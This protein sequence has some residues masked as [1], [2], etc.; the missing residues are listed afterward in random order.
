VSMTTASR[1]G[2]VSTGA[3]DSAV[4]H[5]AHRGRPAQQRGRRDS[6]AHGRSSAPSPG[7]LHTSAGHD[8]ER[9][10]A[11]SEAIISACPRSTPITHRIARGGPTTRQQ[12]QL[13][14]RSVDLEHFLSCLWRVGDRRRTMTDPGSREKG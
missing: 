3:A 12:R 1:G 5:G 8:Y 13:F 9:D 10:P 2:R 11:V 7:C 6:G 4:H 14:L